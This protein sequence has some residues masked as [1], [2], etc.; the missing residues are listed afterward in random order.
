MTSFSADWNCVIEVEADGEHAGQ[1]R[2]LIELHRSGA[3]EVF[4][5][6]TSASEN[7]RGSR[8]LPG[9]YALFRNRLEALGWGDLSAI[10][11]LLTVGL[12]FL[13][14]SKLA[15]DHDDTLIDE[16]WQ[17]IAPNIER[18][19]HRHRQPLLVSDENWIASRDLAKWRNTWCDVHSAHSHI[20]AG[21]DV[22]VTTN[23]TDFQRHADSLALLGLRR[24]ALPKEA[25]A[26]VENR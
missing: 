4:V 21:R 3:C 9:S 5:L 1:V 6:A 8:T 17:I 16:L 10:P 7:L 14:S 25:V 15:G 18:D 13:G 24:I 20:S 11:T 23:T 22:F 12:T 26:L 19:P 2:R